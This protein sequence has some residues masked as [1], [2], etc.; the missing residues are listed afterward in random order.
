VTDRQ[1]GRARLA[2]GRCPRRERYGHLHAD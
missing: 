2:L 1:R